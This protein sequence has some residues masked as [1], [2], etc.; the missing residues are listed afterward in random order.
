MTGTIF[1]LVGYGPCRGI[2]TAVLKYPRT[3]LYGLFIILHILTLHTSQV[4][5]DEA[6]GDILAFLSGSD[7]IES[8]DRLLR[9]RAPASNAGGSN[10]LQLYV[11][12]I[13]AS[14]PPEQQ[15]KVK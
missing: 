12:S 13:Y 8:L 15:M 4:H 3:L 14:M 2:S 10:G 6:A 7:E 5:Q 9:D 1:F 11:V